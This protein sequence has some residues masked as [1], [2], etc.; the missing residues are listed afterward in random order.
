MK[1]LGQLSPAHG[2]NRTRKRLGRGVGSGLGK[3]AGKGHK[4][5]KARKSGG[6]RI[7]FEGGQTPLYRRV[8]KRGFT[9]AHPKNSC[10]VNISHLKGFGNGD[11]VTPQILVEKKII[12]IPKARHVKIKLLGDGTLDH[13][14]HIEVHQCSQGARE[15]VTQ[16]GGSVKILSTVSSS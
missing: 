9:G 1:H 12:N 16:A 13:A 6:T 15:A 5:Q 10:T 3:T 11:S 14:L 7:G 2:S 4:G 8:P